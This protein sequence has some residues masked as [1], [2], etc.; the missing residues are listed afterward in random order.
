MILFKSNM[1]I[2]PAILL[3]DINFVDIRNVWNVRNMQAYYGVRQQMAI[4]D[5]LI[6]NSS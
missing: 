6:F 2:V 5:H 3:L 1:I 4:M